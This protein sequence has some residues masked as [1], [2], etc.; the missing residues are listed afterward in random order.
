M[1]I[2]ED[3][4]LQYELATGGRL[5]LRKTGMEYMLAYLSIYR[6]PGVESVEDRNPNLMSTLKLSSLTVSMIIRVYCCPR[7][8]FRCT[9]KRS[10]V[11]MNV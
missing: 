11:I 8:P 6:Q 7:N 10:Y 9:S 2:V 4:A 1:N 3:V 5:R